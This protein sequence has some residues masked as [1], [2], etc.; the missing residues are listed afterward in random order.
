MKNRLLIAILSLIISLP[1]FALDLDDAKSQGLVGEKIN[2]YI[3]LI[4][5]S[6]EVK[7]LIDEVNAKRKAAY[8]KVAAKN[9]LPI[10]DVEM[11][12]G[13]KLIEKAQPGEIV[14]TQTGKWVKK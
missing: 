3:G 6:D 12:A 13:K 7:T 11:L 14:E 8:A 5:E 10:K 9:N 4:K 1:A 2:G